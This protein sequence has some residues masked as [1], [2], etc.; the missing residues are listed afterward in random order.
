MVRRG[1][2]G[3]GGEKKKDFFHIGKYFLQGPP[4]LW[5]AHPT[6]LWSSL[7]GLGGG[8][9]LDREK[10]FGEKKKDFWGEKK[11]DF[12]QLE[13]DSGGERE[14]WPGSCGRAQEKKEKTRK[15]RLELS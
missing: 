7:S 3:K 13:M 8:P 15:V 6:K 4:E 9:P 11:K 14:E 5:D 12:L 2:E 10:T 1:G